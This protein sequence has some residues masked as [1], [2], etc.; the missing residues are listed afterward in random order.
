MFLL[1][2]ILPAL[3]LA[4]AI[5]IVVGDPPWL[6]RRLPHPVEIIGRAIADFERQAFTEEA[7]P[8]ERFRSGRRT[9]LIVVGACIA[10][11]LV[12]QWLCLLLPFGWVL[13]GLLMSTLI[14]QR[15]LAEHVRAVADGLEQGLAGGRR[16]VARIVGRDPEQLDQH[17]VARAAV[18]SLAENFSDG[19]VAPVFYAFSLGLPGLLAY[20]AINTADSMIGHRSERYLHFGRF[21]ARLDDVANWPPARLAAG[22]LVAGAWLAPG[23][24]HRDARATIEQDAARHRSPNAGWPEAAMAGALDIR[25]SGPRAYHGEMTADPWIGSGTP[26]LTPADIHRALRLF[27]RSAGVMTGLIAFVWLLI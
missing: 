13:L 20:K 10:L 21:A 24:S 3:L 7:T 2:G 8:L 6:Y 11:G 4:L 25:L 18:E 16:A 17:G 23:A 22:L 14:A 1:D 9:T 12:V 5:D 19:V 15:S 26:A 27:W